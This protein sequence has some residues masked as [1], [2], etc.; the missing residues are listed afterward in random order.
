VS[1]DE[2]KFR[3][4][5][6]KINKFRLS[7]IFLFMIMM[8][9]STSI[10]PMT[11]VA[12]TLLCW[13]IFAVCLRRRRCAP[14]L[15]VGVVHKLAA[16][17]DGLVAAY[18]L[19][20]E[21]ASSPPEHLIVIIPGN[22]GQPLFYADTA[23]ALSS[24]VRDARVVVLSHAGHCALAGAR[25]YFDLAAQRQHALAGVRAAVRDAPKGVS[26]TL[27]GHS[28]GGWIVIDLLREREFSGA[29]AL[30]WMPTLAHIGASRNG[31]RLGPLLFYGRTV[32]G[33]V[34]AALSACPLWLQ[35]LAALAYLPR[36]TASASTAVDAVLAIVSRSVAVN[37]LYMAADELAR[38]REPDALHCA[39]VG[40]RASA[41]FARGDAWN[42]HALADAAAASALLKG[43][44]VVHAAEGT[45]HG[46]VLHAE[47]SVHVAKL[48]AELIFQQREESLFANPMRKRSKS[49]A[50]REVM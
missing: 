47:Q 49:R 42:D 8:I 28:I 50:K 10:S 5:S 35:R 44:R 30:L 6:P 13:F 22:P 38:L 19:T 11:L 4:R 14:L 21:S 41:I 33:A 16:A 23:I 34:A 37:A 3:R 32:T 9:T 18:T 15:P 1:A 20:K 24:F 45:A 27:I 39:R 26:L 40:A 43:A 17:S 36:G 7:F 12:L 46:F 31:Q 48:S 25:G 29:R 2:F